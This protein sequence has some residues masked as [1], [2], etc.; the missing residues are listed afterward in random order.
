MPGYK[1]H[2]VG[3][4]IAYSVTLALVLLYSPQ[5]LL[6]GSTWITSF[7]PWMIN[8]LKQIIIHSP[9]LP[10]PEACFSKEIR[11]ILVLFEWFLFA[12]MGALLPDFDTKSKG[13]KWMYWFVFV[14]C[15]ALLGLRRY[16]LISLIAMIM[17]IPLLFNHR[18]LFHRVWFLSIFLIGICFWLQG[19]FPRYATSL[20]IDTI[21]VFTGAISHLY[22]DLGLKRM[23]RW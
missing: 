18:G 4:C 20:T 14:L 7:V 3:G 17:F 11:S 13:Q 19:M 21:F 6:K 22:L 1:G 10:N 2:L 16:D 8:S 23:F 15:I 9:S 12:L 5:A